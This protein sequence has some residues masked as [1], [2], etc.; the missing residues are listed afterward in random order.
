MS[1]SGKSN[2]R[3]PILRRLLSRSL[4]RRQPPPPARQP[5]KISVYI[6]ARQQCADIPGFP[7]WPHEITLSETYYDP[8]SWHSARFCHAGRSVCGGGCK[9]RAGFLCCNFNDNNNH[10]QSVRFFRASYLSR[11]R[12]NRRGTGIFFSFLW[13]RLS[14]PLTQPMVGGRKKRGKRKGRKK[15]T[16]LTASDSVSFQSARIRFITFLSLHLVDASRVR[17]HWYGRGGLSCDYDIF[18]GALSSHSISLG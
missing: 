12:W 6:I 11:S 3:D 9:T 1:L 14:E 2:I 10:W 5:C 4:S 17:L 18:L 8:Y 16:T 7:M 13:L 15:K